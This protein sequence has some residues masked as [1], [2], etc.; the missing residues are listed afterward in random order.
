[1]QNAENILYATLRKTEAK[2]KDEVRRVF[3]HNNRH[4]EHRQKIIKKALNA[5]TKTAYNNDMNSLLKFYYKETSLSE[6]LKDI[7]T[8]GSIL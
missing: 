1:M 3:Y 4:K 5:V 8:K 7:D 2:I 6:S